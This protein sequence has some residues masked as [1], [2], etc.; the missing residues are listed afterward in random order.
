MYPLSYMSFATRWSR[1]DKLSPPE[2]A[3]HLGWDTA[4]AWGLSN[5]AVQA[6]LVLLELGMPIPGSALVRSGRFAGQRLF[7]GGDALA[8]WLAQVHE[9]PEVTLLETGLEVL[10]ERFFG[11]R[12]IAVICAGYPDG[13]LVSLSNGCNGALIAHAAHRIHPQEIRFWT[14]P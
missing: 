7:K 5:G 11:R 9:V 3:A 13:G 6:S 12:G 1:F 14:L 2:L 4:L 8:D 10:P